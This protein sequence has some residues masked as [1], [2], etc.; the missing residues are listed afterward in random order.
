[1]KW[2]IKVAQPRFPRKGEIVFLGDGEKYVLSRL[3]PQR[4]S[5]WPFKVTGDE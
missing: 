5:R 2:S 4:V 1:M 3:I